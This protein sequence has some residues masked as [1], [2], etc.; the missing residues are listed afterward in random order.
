M[1][2]SFFFFTTQSSLLASHAK[3]AWLLS[4]VEE[5]A[6][7]A[8][9]GLF[10]ILL[11]VVGGKDSHLGGIGDGMQWFWLQ[12]GAMARSLYSSVSGSQHH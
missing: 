4:C 5:C 7:P 11:A 3:F 2:L 10:E 9:N 1:S 6:F 12:S 8:I